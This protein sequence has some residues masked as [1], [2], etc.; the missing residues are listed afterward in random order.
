[1][2]ETTITETA[3]TTDTILMVRPAAFGYNPETAANN[4]FQRAPGQASAE[5]IA[6]EARREFD[7][8]VAKLRAAGIEVVVMEDKAEPVC[9]DAVFPNNWV[10]FHADRTI[11]TYPMFSAI[12]RQER[13]DDILQE[14]LDRFGFHRRLLFEV[15]E[16]DG[17]FLEG[18][19]SMVIDRPHRLVY[20]CLSE[21]TNAWLLRDYCL[22]RNYDPVPFR[23]YDQDG[24]VVYHT[25]VMMALGEDFVVICMDSVTDRH[26]RARLIDNFQKTGKEVVEISLAQ[27][28]SFAGNMLQVRNRE[29]KSFLVMSERA[30]LSLDPEQISRLEKHAQLLH[31]PLDTIEK[32]GGGSA[33]CMMAEIFRPQ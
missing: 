9:P 26:D 11:I 21:R 16:N 15:S 25:N 13:R 23:A 2:S 10:S 12:R 18:T 22:E 7:A 4:A 30:Y 1:M 32:H 33:R 5:E 17:Q 27:M 19:G 28:A 20:A 3:Q 8:L 31:S 6:R 24:R 29:G 14:V